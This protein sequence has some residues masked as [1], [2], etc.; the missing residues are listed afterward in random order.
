[1]VD[2]S[3]GRLQYSRRAVGVLPVQRL[4]DLVV[5]PTSGNRPPTISKSTR[6]HPPMTSNKSHANGPRET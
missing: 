3:H 6:S 4:K 1:M 5:A 2:R